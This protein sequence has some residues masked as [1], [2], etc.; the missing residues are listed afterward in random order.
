MCASAKQESST[1]VPVLPAPLLLDQI[2]MQALQ[3]DMPA[4][5]AACPATLNKANSTSTVTNLS[6]LFAF[7]SP[8]VVSALLSLCPLAQFILLRMHRVPRAT[9]TLHTNLPLLFLSSTSRAA[10]V[11]RGCS[12]AKYH[13]I[14]R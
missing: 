14:D 7:S 5:I 6:L 13:Q 10:A 3:R 2:L 1:P 12:H 9:G 11:K 8:F 4:C